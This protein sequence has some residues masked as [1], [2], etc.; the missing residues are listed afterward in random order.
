[1]TRD[2]ATLKNNSVGQD[3]VLRGSRDNVQGEETRL[4][5]RTVLAEESEW[6]PG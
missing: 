5:M 2:T 6:G 1:M 4:G 3:T